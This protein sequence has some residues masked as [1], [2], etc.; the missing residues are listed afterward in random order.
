MKRYFD[1]FINKHLT[2][3]VTSPA[4]EVYQP[5]DKIECPYRLGSTLRYL[6][7]DVTDEEAQ[8]MYDKHKTQPMSTVLKEL[9]SKKPKT[10]SPST[11]PNSSYS[12]E[13]PLRDQ[14]HTASN[15]AQNRG[16]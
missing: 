15:E 4:S 5:G 11:N 1:R 12:A 2:E 6:G 14:I 13:D 7:N 16:S 9:E 8:Q 10:V 3:N